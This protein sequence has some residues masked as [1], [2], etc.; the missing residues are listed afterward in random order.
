MSKRRPS[1]SNRR[2]KLANPPAIEN[3]L[4]QEY[5]S[6]RLFKNSYTRSG[7]RKEVKGWSVKIQHLG[8][9]HTFS[10]LIDDKGNR[11]PSRRKPFTKPFWPRAGMPP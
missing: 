3:S 9:R 7:V 8:R 4:T 6:Q 10:L 1:G 2:Q 5:W 11:R